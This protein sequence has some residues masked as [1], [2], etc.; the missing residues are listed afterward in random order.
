M[1][2]DILEI[3]FLKQ[4]YWVI[5]IGLILLNLIAFNVYIN[6]YNI[7]LLPKYFVLITVAII[8]ALLLGYRDHG[9]GTDTKTY[10]YLYEY[11]FIPMKTLTFRKDFLWDGL[12]YIFS[13][14]TSDVQYL[15]IFVAIGYVFLPI[16]GIQKL[17]KQNTV[18]FFFL[19]LISPNFFLYGA[20]GIRNGLAASIFLFS[21]RYYNS[22]K[23]WIFLVLSVFMHLSMILPLFF[24]IVGKY[25]KN[26][27]I[28]LCIWGCL[29]LFST[30]GINFL[31]FL[32]FSF[33]RLDA[34]LTGGDIRPTSRVLNIP[35]NFLVYS[36]FPV[37]V[38]TYFILVRKKYDDFFLR[39]SVV[40][41]LC[42]CVYISAFHIKFV[43]RFA[44]ISEFLMPL[45]AIYPFFKFKVIK[46][47]EIY[48]ALFLISIFLF[49]SY[50]IFIL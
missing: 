38:A 6:K 24:F 16:A 28:L 7:L 9:V 31:S 11:V 39:L 25:F 50:K 35:I 12:V 18:Y 23:Q 32:P 4:L 41:I 36:I 46:Y 1:G 26:Y 17:L 5:L 15:L 14:L 20:N 29:L 42:S 40:Y 8:I 45:V 49:K 19:F 21:F 10:V 34:Y 27:K 47:R 43:E 44:Y 30:L 37:I 48:I 3:L 13:R 33:S 2:L 22:K